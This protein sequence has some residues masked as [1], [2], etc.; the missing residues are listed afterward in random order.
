MPLTYGWIAGYVV[1]VFYICIW[2]VM[3]RVS[4]FKNNTSQAVR[5]PKAV[6]YPD[7]VQQVDIVIQGRARIIT[8]AGESWDSWFESEGVSDDFIDS[9]QQPEHQNREGL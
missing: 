8:P 6:A 1:Y 9:R 5:L 3:E 7:S 2:A 4:I